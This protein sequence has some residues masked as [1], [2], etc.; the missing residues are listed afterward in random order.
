M[1]R[2]STNPVANLLVDSFYFLFFMEE[3]V[4]TMQQI[5]TSCNLIFKKIYKYPVTGGIDDI[6]LLVVSILE[7]ITNPSH[8]LLSGVSILPEYTKVPAG[9]MQISG[10]II[11]NV[12]DYGIYSQVSR[13]VVYSD[14]IIADSK[15]GF[16]A[17]VYGDSATGHVQSDKTVTFKDSLVVSYL[18]IQL[19]HCV[20][21]DLI[22]SCAK[23]CQ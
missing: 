15:I 17:L 13:S 23:Y 4:F 12:M 19:T 21:S 7:H 5:H 2:Y 6:Y 22:N 9:C 11:H 14:N 20:L 10:F 1:C 16:I 8:F 3:S 18:R